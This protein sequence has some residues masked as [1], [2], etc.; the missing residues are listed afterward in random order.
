VL[1]DMVTR[2]GGAR[3]WADELGVRFVERRPGYA[4][5]WTEERIRNDLARFLAGRAEW[6]SRKEFEAAG[7]KPLRDAV[8]RTGGPERWAAELGVGVPDRRRG[9]MRGWSDAEIERELR[10]LIGDSE[11]WPTKNQFTEAGQLSLLLSLYRHGTVDAWAR[12]LGV[13]RRP[14][15]GDA[16]RRWTEDRVR[17]ELEA[18]CAG[19]DTW[20][21]A[22]EFERAAL[23]RLYRAA[24]RLG[25]V[26]RW[27][28]QL[29][30][31]PPR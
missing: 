18:F 19:R 26:R 29:G 25:G 3:R 14:V 7:L 6:P 2:Y 15:R 24:S 8:R 11:E 12:R 16:P 5:I 9:S 13:R 10:R 30:L 20:P 23:G 27:Q 22:N 17:A 28:R 4:P 1:R 21:T 31:R